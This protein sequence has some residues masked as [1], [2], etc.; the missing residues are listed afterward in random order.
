MTGT[1]TEVRLREVVADL[2]RAHIGGKRSIC[3][4]GTKLLLSIGRKT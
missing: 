2:C 1:C 3:F 4:T